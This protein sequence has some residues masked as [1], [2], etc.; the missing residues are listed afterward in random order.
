M[1]SLLRH[2]GYSFL[3]D[4]N[5]KTELIRLLH[6]LLKILSQYISFCASNVRGEDQLVKIEISR[7]VKTGWP[8]WASTF[9]E[10][11]QKIHI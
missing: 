11:G 10:S 8:R 2:W 4:L 7:T 5:F 3:F 6:E 1:C 9:I